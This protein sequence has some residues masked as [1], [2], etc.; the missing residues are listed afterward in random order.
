MFNIKKT[1]RFEKIKMETETR[2]LWKTGN[3]K[4][5]NLDNFWVPR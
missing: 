5:Q 3:Y 1:A 4:F 2:L